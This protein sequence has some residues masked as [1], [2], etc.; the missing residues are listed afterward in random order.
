MPAQ[1][2]SGAFWSEGTS[3]VNG[4]QDAKTAADNI[5]AAWPS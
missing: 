1:V 2:G 3:F 4:D 5:Q